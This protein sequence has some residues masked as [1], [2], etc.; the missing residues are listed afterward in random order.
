MPRSEIRTLLEDNWKPDMT[1][2]AAMALCVAHGL[3]KVSSKAVSNAITN[4]RLYLKKAKKDKPVPKRKRRKSLSLP[5]GPVEPLSEVERL[6]KRLD[7]YRDLLTRV[8]METE[9]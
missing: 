4:I 3:K 7:L 5:T 6:R 1:H 9:L 8:L 2:K